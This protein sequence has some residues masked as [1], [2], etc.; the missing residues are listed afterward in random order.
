MG[1]AD[2]PSLILPTSLLTNSQQPETSDQASLGTLAAGV[3][4]LHSRA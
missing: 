3:L 4:A 2:V 1:Y